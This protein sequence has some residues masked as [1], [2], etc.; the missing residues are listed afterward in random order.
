[1]MSPKNTKSHP[2]GGYCSNKGTE[3]HQDGKLRE[4]GRELEA[5]YD[6]EESYNLPPA[7]TAN[8]CM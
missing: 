5:N 3:R 7:Y 2:G 1:M 4:G 8:P 6:K